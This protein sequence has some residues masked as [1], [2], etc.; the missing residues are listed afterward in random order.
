MSAAFDVRTDEGLRHALRQVDRAGSWDVPA[1]RELLT[2]VRRHAVRNAA[3]VSAT[4]GVVADRGLVDD[5]LTAAWTVLHRNTAEVMNADRPWAYLMSSAQRQVAADARAQQLLTSA[6]AVRGRARHLLPS[7]IRLVGAAPAELALAFRHEPSGPSDGSVLPQ[8]GHVD[9]RPLVDQSAGP[10]ATLR[11]ERE[12]WYSAIIQLLVDHGADRAVTAAAL[13]RLADLFTTTA[14]GLWERE[15]RRDP[16]L[17]GLGLS[18]DQCGALVALI[19]GSRRFRHN[20]KEDSLLFP[21]RSAH[22]RGEPGHSRPRS[23]AAWPDTCAA[24]PAC[25]SAT[26]A[27]QEP[28]CAGILSVSREPPPAPRSVSC[29]RCDR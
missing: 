12:P 10:R 23:R 7:R 3:R 18:A 27:G 24:R 17:A 16:V 5:V 15:A 29:A 6:S 21:I 4:T 13:D 22:S 26:A 8:V 20:G 19:A 11:T 1:G 25:N 14:G 9:A 2:E 28:P